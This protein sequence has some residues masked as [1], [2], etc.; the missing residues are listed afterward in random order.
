MK[1]DG[2]SQHYRVQMPGESLWED[3]SNTAEFPGFLSP[4]SLLSLFL[5]DHSG[6]TVQLHL[7][8]AWLHTD[9]L[10]SSRVVNWGGRSSPR[11]MTLHSILASRWND[12]SFAYWPKSNAWPQ[13]SVL[14]KVTIPTFHINLFFST[15]ST[16]CFV[17]LS[18]RHFQTSSFFLEWPF[19][20]S[21]LI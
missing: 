12:Q 10:P 20:F 15:C 11:K 16:K 18:P 17:S 14:K 3:L 13:S 4:K 21:L 9:N 7:L 1:R 2:I 5:P 6:I 8:L 19:L